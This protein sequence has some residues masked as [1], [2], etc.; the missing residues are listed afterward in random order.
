[1]I[2]KCKN[3]D[4]VSGRSACDHCPSAYECGKL[5]SALEILTAGAPSPEPSYDQDHKALVG[6]LEE[7]EF[8]YPTAAEACALQSSTRLIRALT[9][10]AIR[11]LERRWRTPRRHVESA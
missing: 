6:L 2:V 11:I 1:V 5:F 10:Q 9:A 8:G 3:G 7:A 4:N